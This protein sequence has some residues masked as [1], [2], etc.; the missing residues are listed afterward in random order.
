MFWSCCGCKT[1]EVTKTNSSRHDVTCVVVC[2]PNGVIVFL[3][4]LFPA[5]TPP[6]C[7]IFQGSVAGVAQQGEWTPPGLRSAGHQRLLQSRVQRNKDMSPCR[8][9]RAHLERSSSS[10]YSSSR[11]VELQTKQNAGRN[12]AD[13]TGAVL[14]LSGSF[15]TLPLE[16]SLYVCFLLWVTLRIA[17]STSALPAVPVTL[18][19]QVHTQTHKNAKCGEL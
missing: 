17:S 10:S 16:F 15:K 8:E 12:G 11:L 13:R 14:R 18:H 1:Q 3:S 4:H 9:S 2:V 7:F 19:T 6:L 5:D